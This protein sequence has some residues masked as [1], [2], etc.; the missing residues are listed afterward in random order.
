MKIGIDASRIEVGENLTGVGR[1]ALQIISHL[2]HQIPED[3]QVVL[4]SRRPLRAEI[5]PLPK[6]WE[7]KILNWSPRRLWT[8]IRLSFEILFHPVDVLFVPAHVL[9]LIRPAKSVSVIHDVSALHSP[10]AY[11]WFEKWYS[12]YA[13][14]LACRSGAVIVPSDFVRQDLIKYLGP[15]SRKASTGEM[16]EKNIFTIHHGVEEKF[17]APIAELEIQKVAEKYNL[18][19]KKYFLF[20]GRIENKKNTENLV[21]AFEIFKQTNVG[22]DFK[23]ILVG[24]FGFGGENT[25]RLI[26]NSVFK[27]SI[28]APGF[29]DD[30]EMLP[31]LK[32]AA[33]YV[34]PPMLE[35][36]GMPI[37]EAFA[38]GVPILT[39]THGSSP[40]I[41]SDA[42]FEVDCTSP[43]K[44]AE[45]MVLMVTGGAVSGEKIQKGIKIAREHNWSKTA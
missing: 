13:A 21:K 5:F 7:N 39:S 34:F 22:K 3:V 14:R 43:E 42:S 30:T 15:P 6:N 26:D 10:D 37:L 20:V 27:N 11:N 38:V 29:L 25:K 16:I 2:R 40:E 45:S 33:A 4:Y 1:Y 17:F 28:I 8:Q 35:G 12:L 31:L 36:F 19:P 41:A 9:P 23:L 24:S 32:G 18:I 44:M